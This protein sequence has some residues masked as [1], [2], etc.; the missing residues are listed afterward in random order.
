VSNGQLLG[1]RIEELN[2][3]KSKSNVVG[4]VYSQ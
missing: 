1:R 2:K 4:V 3:E